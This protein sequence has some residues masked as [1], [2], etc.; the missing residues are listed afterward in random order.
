[1]FIKYFLTFCLLLQSVSSF[2]VNMMLSRRNMLASSVCLV[3]NKVLAIDNKDNP[4]LTPAEME[5]YKKL[6]KEAQ[7]IQSIIDINIKAQD[8]ALKNIKFNNTK[9]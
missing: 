9:I 1:M 6:L 3:S 2:N 5:E 8:E 4:P 7:R